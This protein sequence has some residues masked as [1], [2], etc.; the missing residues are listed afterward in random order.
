MHKFLGVMKWVAGV[1]VLLLLICGGGAAFLVPMISKQIEAQRDR[2]R[3]TLVVVEPA[4]NGELVRTVSAPGVIAPKFTANISARVSAKIV[5][6]NVDAGATVKEG[7]V[8]IELDSKD[9][10]AS[11][12]GAKARLAA[13]EAALTG[14]IANLAAEEA[15]IL[16]ARATYQN[17][18]ADFERQQSLFKSGDVSQQALDVAKTEMER[19][20]ASLEAASKA[21]DSFQSN[22]EAARARVES[23]KADVDR[24][25]QNVEYCVIRSPLTGVVVKRNVNVGEVA[26]GTIQNV[27]TA[28][29]VVEDQ[30]R[31][32]V[33]A[34]LAETDGP[35]VKMAQRARVFVN[36]Y[37]DV[38]FW[39]TVS[40]IALTTQRHTDQTLFLETEIELDPVEQMLASNTTA[41]VEVEIE[42]LRDVLLVPSQ[43]VMDKRVDTLP[44]KLRDENPLINKDKTF[45][46]VVMLYKNGKAEYTPVRTIA[47]NITKT[48]IAEGIA[49]GDPV[50][51]GPFS[52]LQTLTDGSAVRTEDEDAKNKKKKPGEPEV[53][54]KSENKGTG[55]G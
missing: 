47:S 14:T 21:L 27:G 15:R 28:L 4:S 1:G 40:R 31:L 46:K 37:P 48:A 24:A 25:Q 32:L 11:L 41:N 9:L 49:A 8:L 34:R 55:A 43:A 16:G 12:A 19:A 30:S 50:I 5:A 22:I 52:A 13:D 42:T 36:G 51:V 20:Q 3:G 26:L 18:V 45:A 6:I 38:T 39:G 29:L 23:S 7:D 10:V 54:D 53:A 17:A 44:Q 2:A 35:R 33:K